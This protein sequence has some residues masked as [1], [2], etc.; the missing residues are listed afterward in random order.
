MLSTVEVQYPIGTK[1]KIHYI[2]YL[3]F[4]SYIVSLIGSFTPFELLHR[5]G[6]GS[7]WRNWIQLGACA[8]SFGLVAI[9]CMYFIGN[10][11]IVL[12]GDESEI[13]L[14]HNATYTAVS[15]ILPIVVIFLGLLAAD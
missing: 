14:Y 8:V 6:Y 9:W 3:I 10:R 12:G 2:P 15:T 4:I 1:P 7:G 11:A 13:Q 5:W